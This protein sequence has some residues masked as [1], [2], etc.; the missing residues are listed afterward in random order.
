MVLK[1]LLS[2][3]R[4]VIALNYE[5]TCS[6]ITASRRWDGGVYVYTKFSTIQGKRGAAWE[7]G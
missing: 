5:I 4:R 1:E 7:W 6:K 2:R 3:E